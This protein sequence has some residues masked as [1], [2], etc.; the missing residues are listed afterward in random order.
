MMVSLDGYIEGSDHDL[1]WHHVDK[2][3][4]EF[5]NDQLNEVDTIVFGRRTYELMESYWPAS[6]GIEDDPETAR[7]MNNTPKVVISRTLQK[8]KETENWK[9][10]RLVSE[11]VKEEIEKLKNQ[12]GRDIIVLGSNNLCVSLLEWGLLD[13]LRI[14]I[15]PVMIGNG[16]SLFVGLKNKEELA[17][18]KTRIFKNGNVLLSYKCMS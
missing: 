14:M 3:F 4:G 9:N 2:E 1:S 15:N 11:N 8:V 7:L 18:S 5:A 10:V 13:E 16:T 17:L 6:S 12:E